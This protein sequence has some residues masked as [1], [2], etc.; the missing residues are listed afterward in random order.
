M[1]K[2]KGKQKTRCTPSCEIIIRDIE[3]PDDKEIGR[4]KDEAIEWL[5]ESLGFGDEDDELAKEIFREIVRTG[6]EGV[7]SKEIQEKTGVSQGAIVYHLNIFRRSGM[8]IREGRYY[9]LKRSSLDRTLTDME[10]IILRKFEKM[11]KIAKM[12]EEEF[13]EF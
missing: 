12:L 6:K 7:R 11:K 1:Q 13:D 5:F 8:I 4:N 3:E 10:K 9:Y 2:K